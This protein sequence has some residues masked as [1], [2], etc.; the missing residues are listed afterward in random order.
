MH[1][2]CN[3]ICN[4]NDAITKEIKL[5]EEKQEGRCKTFYLC[6]GSNGIQIFD[7][8]ASK[9]V[10]IAMDCDLLTYCYH[11]E[12]CTY[13]LKEEN[14]RHVVIFAK[15]NN[16]T[17]HATIK[18]AIFLNHWLDKSWE[19]NI[20]QEEI[21]FIQVF[22]W[23]NYFIM[24]TNRAEDLK[25]EIIQQ[26]K[27]NKVCRWPIT[28][29]SAFY[30]FHKHK[31]KKEEDK[32]EDK[33]E[34]KKEDKN[35][36]Q[37]FE[38][39]ILIPLVPINETNYKQYYF[40]TRIPL[41]IRLK[42]IT[43]H[44]TKL[45]QQ[46][47][48]FHS[49][50]SVQEASDILGV[51]FALLNDIVKKEYCI[52]GGAVMKLACPDTLWEQ[53][54]DIDIFIPHSEK[55][56]SNVRYLLQLLDNSGR[57]IFTQGN[58]I[59]TAIGDIHTRRIQV[60]VTKEDNIDN[61]VRKFDIPAVK[62]VYINGL[63]YASP[64]CQYSW[65]KRKCVLD[66]IIPCQPH[67]LLKIERKGF[68]LTKQAQEY[69]RNTFGKCIFQTQVDQLFETFPYLVPKDIVP[70]K[71]QY[72]QLYKLHKYEKY[73]V[74][75][76]DTSLN[77]MEDFNFYQNGDTKQDEY[78]ISYDCTNFSKY[79]TYISYHEAKGPS[80]T[81]SHIQSSHSITLYVNKCRLFTSKENGCS[82]VVEKEDLPHLFE[83]HLKDIFKQ[84]Q[85]RVEILK[86][87]TFDSTSLYT[88]KLE[89]SCRIN[90]NGI[91]IMQRFNDTYQAGYT[92]LIIRPGYLTIEENLKTVRL[93]CLVS[94]VNIYR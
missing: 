65:L 52:C 26:C 84:L 74:N 72:A 79:K 71:N 12:S 49:I 59:F 80:T 81:V 1:E 46:Q 54:S 88:F 2:D 76:S 90:R 37:E 31:V 87:K 34:N 27:N 14:D 9:M 24:D 61:V 8:I 94:C 5:E 11:G 29:M 25:N 30:L 77:L 92:V 93:R 10:T 64:S 21:D 55:Q 17:L 15:P 6:F 63:I 89:K 66:G 16:I 32:N 28:A 13:H 3:A 78:P 67:R 35:K 53:N 83:D 48:F 38:S 22:E 82:V 33:S 57:T 69:V 40:E 60:I 20:F 41:Q 85:S 45:E 91:P 86:E 51:E 47:C 44:C 4:D 23:F 58:S 36:K 7:G 18:D 75:H 56:E 50:R 68:R 73:D 39:E 42:F 43:K 62:A 70:L 19:V